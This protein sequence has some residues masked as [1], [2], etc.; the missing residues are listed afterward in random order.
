MNELFEKYVYLTLELNVLFEQYTY[1]ILDLNGISQ[2]YTYLTLEL[3][4]LSQKYMN[5]LCDFSHEKSAQLK[6]CVASKDSEL[7]LTSKFFCYS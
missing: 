6:N 2:K 3:N 4:G 1:P 5:L 7:N